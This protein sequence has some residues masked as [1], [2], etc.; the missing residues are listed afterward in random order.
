MP[1]SS[2]PRRRP[3]LC[4]ASFRAWLLARRSQ[5]VGQSGCEEACPIAN[6]LSSLFDAPCE[7]DCNGYVRG[8]SDTL[9]PLPSWVQSYIRAIDFACPFDEVTGEQ[10]LRLLDLVE[11][12]TLG[13]GPAR[14]V[15]SPLLPFPV[16]R[17]FE[18]IGGRLL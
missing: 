4:S 16:V 5:V 2:R 13:N 8:D 1:C 6:W 3:V 15:S 7:V 12:E 14:P 17:P 10:A 9:H 11:R 18:S